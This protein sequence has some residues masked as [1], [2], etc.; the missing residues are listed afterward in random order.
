M[1]KDTLTDEL[2]L[3]HTKHK[4]KSELLEM[5]IQERL[6]KSLKIYYENLISSYNTILNCTNDD[7]KIIKEVIKGA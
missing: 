3:L 7:M 5:Y 4:T 6:N 2:K 1:F